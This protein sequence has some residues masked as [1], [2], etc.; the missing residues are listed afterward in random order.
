PVPL[1][2]HPSPPAVA[3][4]AGLFLVASLRSGNLNVPLFP[5]EEPAREFLEKVFWARPRS[6]EF[7]IGHPLMLLGLYMFFNKRYEKYKA[8]AILAL[9]A[10][11]FGQVSLVNTFCHAHIP[12]LMSLVRAVYGLA[13][14]ALGG[15]LLILCLKHLKKS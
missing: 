9:S 8:S 12:F 4:L 3:V 14:G 6:K 11:M 5:F 1:D 13:L 7:L 2:R 15:A 10:G